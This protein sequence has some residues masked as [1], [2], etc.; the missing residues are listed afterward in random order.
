M[1]QVPLQPAAAGEGAAGRGRAHAPLRA[2]HQLDRTEAQQGV[3]KSSRPTKH[4]RHRRRRHDPHA[5]AV[6]VNKYVQI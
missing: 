6:R 3:R 4:G 5:R 2:H 1:V